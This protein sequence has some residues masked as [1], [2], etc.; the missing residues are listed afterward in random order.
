MIA[1]VNRLSAIATI[2]AEHSRIRTLLATETE[3]SLEVGGRVRRGL[4]SGQESSIKALIGHLQLWESI[5]LEAL[6]SFM[7]GEKPWICDSAYDAFEAGAKINLDSDA[8]KRDW[9]V[10]RVVQSWAQTAACLDATLVGLSDAQWSL[11]APYS[12]DSPEDLGGLLQS[13]LT[14]PAESP[15]EHLANHLP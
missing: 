10:Q 2:H 8:L 14:A 13:L 4:F 3:K 7:Q 1:T 15:F 5:A 11:P 12:L 9:S 6:Y